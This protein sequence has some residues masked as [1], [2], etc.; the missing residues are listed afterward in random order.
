[1]RHWY[2]YNGGR[3]KIIERDQQRLTQCHGGGLLG[4]RQ[5]RLQSMG[6]VAAILDAI[7]LAPLVDG[8]KWSCF[9]GQFRGSAK[10]HLG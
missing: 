5:P 4:W 1:V 3:Q 10:M 6:R 9:I 2:K 8:L 7:A